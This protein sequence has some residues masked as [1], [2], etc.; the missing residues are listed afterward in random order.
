MVSKS[1][2]PAAGTA[3]AAN[4]QI[5]YAINVRV[6]EAAT[7]GVLTL[8]DTLGA[9]LRFVEGSFQTPAGGKCQATG[10]T[11]RCELAAGAAVGAHT[12]RYQA[13]VDAQATGTLNNRVTANGID[14]PA[15]TECQVSHPIA[16]VPAPVV[17]VS[18]SATPAAGSAV[19]AGTVLT[20]ALKVKVEKG[21]T[22]DKVTLTD[23][24]DAGLLYVDGSFSV[25]A[26]A[27]CS[28]AGQ[29]LTCELAAGTATGEHLFTYQ[30]KVRDGVTG[31]LNNTV[32]AAGADQPR[33]TGAGDC[34]TT[35]QVTP[36]TVPPPATTPAVTVKKSATPGSGSTVAVG[37]LI[38]YTLDVT[39]T[40]APTTDK[41]TLKDT[42]GAGLDYVHNSFVTPAGGTCSAAGQLLTCELAA[43][44]VVGSYTFQYQA[45]VRSATEKLDN[46][47]VP[48]G[49][50]LDSPS[51]TS[52]NDC[53][54]SHKAL[55]LTP[56]ATGGSVT[57]VPG[58]A[59][60]AMLLAMLA[61]LGLGY[62]YQVHRGPR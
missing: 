17:K 52:A 31:S 26:G 7:T 25:P 28:A 13:K 30:A 29:V 57:P 20:Y 48:H 54:T 42:L 50:V 56:P 10:Q 22:K 53:Q 39:V 16:T 18:K 62:R 44:T 14:K 1:A 59:P 11:L 32:V 33:C 41:V 24:L 45:R 4:E 38:T 60:W 2:N 46:I 43:G 36:P 49:A 12:F 34:Q 35:H 55:P 47:V 8:T 51:C 3:V 40:Q 37:S 27:T 21:P 15:C 9:G 23:T 58:N 5:A 19:P 61:L 6:A